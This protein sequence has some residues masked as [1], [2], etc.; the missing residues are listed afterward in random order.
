MSS[1]EQ[2]RPRPALF[3]ALGNQEPPA[4]VTI[5]GHDYALERVLKHDSW[6]AS[7][8]YAGP[9]GR[10]MVKFNRVEAIL[11]VPMAWL[12]AWLA[13]REAWMLKELADQPA[14][15]RWSGDVAVD[16]RVVR[17]AVAH[18]WIDGHPLCTGEAVNDDF[19]PE[20]ERLLAEMHRRGLAYVDLHKRENIIVGDD[21]RPYLIDFQISQALPDVWVCDNPLTRPLLWLLQKSDEYHLRKHKVHHRPDQAGAT[22]DELAKSRPWWIR[23]HRLVARP[24]R[25]LRRSLLVLLKVRK[26]GGQAASEV[27][28]E[29]AIQ[30]EAARRA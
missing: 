19:F 11:G 2:A 5:G 24:F 25:T 7:A 8:V 18:D 29:D 3:R 4:V 20:L 17:N 16:G 26:A 13:R 23:L 21:G 30:A 9:A 22:A 15:P 28:P 27:F 10:V 14:I 6:A 12:G 1:G